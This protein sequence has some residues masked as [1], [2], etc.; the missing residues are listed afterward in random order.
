MRAQVTELLTGYGK[1]D[2][3]WFDFSYPRNGWRGLP[4]KG[5]DDWQSRELI[6]LVHRLSPDTL[7]NDRLD[8]PGEGDFM[9]IEQKQLDEPPRGGPQATGVGTVARC[10]ENCHTFSGAW[11]Y[12]RDEMSWKTP[13]L[14]LQLLIQAVARGGN[15]IINVGPTARGQFDSRARERLD[16]YAD[17]MY[18]NGRS[19]HGCGAA[20]E[21]LPEPSKCLYTWNRAANRLYIHILDWPYITLRC[22]GLGRK[23]EYAQF[24]HDASEVRFSDNAPGEQ[25]DPTSPPGGL[26][27]YLP[28]VQPGGTLLPVIELFLKPGSLG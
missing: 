24:L 12:S 17:W 15:F 23:V 26:T 3:I 21:T 25:T 5:R 19:I 7:V 20:P 22:P 8:L 1:I 27:L 14:C 13:K 16:A 10:W 11:S 9:T 4:G 2:L 28:E 6:D 18:V